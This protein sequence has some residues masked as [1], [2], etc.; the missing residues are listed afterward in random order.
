MVGLAQYHNL[1]DR[2]GRCGLK[3]HVLPLTDMVATGVGWN[4]KF[5]LS[6]E[7]P[8]GI[9]GSNGIMTLHMVNNDLPLLLSIDF[10]GSGDGVGHYAEH[11]RVEVHKAAK[12]A[13]D[14]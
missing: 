1:C 14:I 4:S 10:L 12:Q 6:C 7:V 3:P 9:R 5:V 11:C 13:L 2:L 8:V